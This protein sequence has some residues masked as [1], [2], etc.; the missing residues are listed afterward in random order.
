[1]NSTT[2]NYNKIINN[3]LKLIKMKKPDYEGFKWAEMVAHQE[4]NL[5][6]D[7]PLM[8]SVCP[9][10]ALF[11]RKQNPNQPYT[12]KEIADDTIKAYQAGA[13]V[14]HLHS[15]TEDG[16]FGAP[17][18]VLKEIIERIL[19]K[20]PDMIIQPSSTE[21]YVP[22]TTNY[23]YE[24]VKPLVEFFDN[25]KYMESTIFV[26]N[27]YAAEDMSGT[28]HL[29]VATEENSVKTIEYLQKNNIKPVFMNHNME[30]IHNIKEWL[31]KPG[32]LEKPYIMSMGPGMHNTGDTYPDPWG[33]MYIINMMQMM[34]EGSLISL[35]VGGR[36][37]L[38]LSTLGIILG[39]QDIRVG[40]EDHLWMYPHKDDLIQSSADSTRKIA[41][42]A[43]ELGREIATPD[44]ARELMGIT[45]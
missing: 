22:G 31:I 43:K 27:S 40:M 36:N 13:S 23:S 33:M 2:N 15:R 8:I 20:C 38:P 7:K 1:M 16:M 6:M 3:N 17:H 41:N 26:T 24:S 12:P 30:A 29:N 14:A 32:I 28:I 42:I 10:G 39:V 4:K 35:S 11:S 19:D 25:H 21:S 37:W 34:P 45:K 18:K 5:T 44:Q 9:T